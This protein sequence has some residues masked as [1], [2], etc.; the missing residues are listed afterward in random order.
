M[1]GSSSNDIAGS[2]FLEIVFKK[3]FVFEKMYYIYIIIQKQP[4]EFTRKRIT[5]SAS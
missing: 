4:H 3:F 2:D 5:L 1:S